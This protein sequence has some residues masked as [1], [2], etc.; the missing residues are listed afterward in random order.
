[1]TARWKKVEKEAERIEASSPDTAKQKVLT[2]RQAIDL[3][4][5]IRDKFYPR[6]GD[7]ADF[8]KWIGRLEKDLQTLADSILGS[9]SPINMYLVLTDDGSVQLRSSVNT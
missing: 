5:Q 7:T 4:R 1:L 3:R 6:G 9:S 2:L 8:L